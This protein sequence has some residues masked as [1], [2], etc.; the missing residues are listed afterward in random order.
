MIGRVREIGRVRGTGKEIG[1]GKG[2]G[3]DRVVVIR[4]DKVGG[5]IREEEEM[6][7]GNYPT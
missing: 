7:H 5:K 4:K 6:K 1:T 2:I 3:R